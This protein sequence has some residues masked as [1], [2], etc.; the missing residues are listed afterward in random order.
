MWFLSED[1]PYFFE[2]QKNCLAQYK[3]LACCIMPFSSSSFSKCSQA[4]DLDSTSFLLFLA[5]TLCLLEA[6]SIC[7]AS[8]SIWNL[9]LGTAPP[10]VLLP[11]GGV[12]EGIGYAIYK[13][14]EHKPYIR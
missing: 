10:A 2:W 4:L 9:E 6:E 7:C 3:H 14:G 11:L 5:I 12:G 8:T 1:V 13:Y